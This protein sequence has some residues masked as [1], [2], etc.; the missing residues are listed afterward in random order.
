MK[1][2]ETITLNKSNETKT[3]TLSNSGAESFAILCCWASSENTLSFNNSIYRVL[4]NNLGSGKYKIQ[5]LGS[6]TNI[7]IAQNITTF[8]WIPDKANKEKPGI[9]CEAN[10]PMVIIRN[11]IGFT[12]ILMTTINDA[13]N[14]Y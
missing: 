5:V 2:G 10:S 14:K 6:F 4:V 11:G 13:L 1:T 3:V 12:K 7:E 9:S 8:N